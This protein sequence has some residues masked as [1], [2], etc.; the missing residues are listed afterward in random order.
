MPSQPI[1]SGAIIKCR[2]QQTS[3]LF[4][5][6]NCT[7]HHVLFQFHM[8]DHNN[9]ALD[10]CD[11]DAILQHTSN[12][13]LLSI[14]SCVS[15]VEVM[16]P[17]SKISMCH[18]AAFYFQSVVVVCFGHRTG[19]VS[20]CRWPKM[21][22]TKQTKRLQSLCSH[23]FAVCH[24]REEKK[25]DQMKLGQIYDNVHSPNSCKGGEKFFQTNGVAL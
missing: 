9:S 11:T 8:I 23:Q 2:W 15:T 4:A 10:W 13:H 6:A 21:G 18:K 7:H 19:L 16:T 25:D 14:V 22:Y 5:K 12:I 1:S 17:G 3:Q 20:E 24:L